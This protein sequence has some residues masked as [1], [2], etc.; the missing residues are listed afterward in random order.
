MSLTKVFKEYNNLTWYRQK[1]P[2]VTT[3]LTPRHILK[4]ETNSSGPNFS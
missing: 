1:L 4:V 3:L 2:N